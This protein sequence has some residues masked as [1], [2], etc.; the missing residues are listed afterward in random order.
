MSLRDDRAAGQEPSTERDSS[1]PQVLSDAPVRRPFASVVAATHCSTFLVVGTLLALVHATGLLGDTP[2]IVLSVAAP[3]AIGLGVRRHRPTPHWPWTLL[4]LAGLVWSV[5]GAVRTAVESTGDLSADRSLL[6]DA[7]AIGGYT[8]FAVALVRMVRAQGHL[9]RSRSLSLDGVIM[10]MSAMLAS[11]V[12]LVAP[13]L[14]HLDAAPIAKLS[15]V[16]YP[17]ISAGLV[18]VAARLAFGTAGRGRAHNLLLLGMLAILIGDVAYIPL[19]TH[20]FTDLP[21]RL[22]ELPYALAYA[23]IGAAALHPSMADTVRSM[24][25]TPARTNNRFALVAMALMTP[26]MMLLVWSPVST[27]ERVVVGLLAIGLATAAIVRVVFA[28]QAQAEVEEHLSHRAV[29]DELTGM[30]NRT[31]MIELVDRRLD[32]ARASSE[33]LALLFIDLDRFKLVNDTYGHAAGD[34]LLLAVSQRLKASLRGHDSVAR[35]SG[36]EFLIVSSLPDAGAAHRVAERICG[37]FEQP[38]DVIGAAWVTASVGVVVASAE[39]G[40]ADAAELIRDADTAMYEA[41]AAGRAHYAVFDP[42]MRAKSAQRLSI[43]NGLHRAIDEHEFEVFYQP[44]IDAGSETVHGVEALVRWMAPDGMVPPD[45][46]ISVAEDSGLISQIGEIVLRDACTQ[47]ARWRLLPGCENLTLSVNVSARQVIDVDLVAVV[48]E[49]LTETGMEPSALWLEITESLMISDNLDTLSTLS[50]LRNLG[51]H[52]AVDDFGTG[53][54]SLSY[55]HRYPVEQVKIDRQFVS[56]LSDDGDAGG[57][58][59]V[60]AAVIGIAEALDLSIVA[61]GVETE[62]Q[63]GHLTE[64]GCDL[65]Q[66]FHFSRPVPALDLG[67]LLI[68]RNEPE[69]P[70]TSDRPR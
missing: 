37:L 35:L 51:V 55:L 7:F 4:I 54:S 50:G 64:I 49:V 11:W 68:E 58:A 15:I 21:G 42:S 28:A 52:L 23:L 19:E 20:L 43:Y 45:Q 44:L 47:V 12:T 18:Y 6:P 24:R 69:R 57:D 22:L 27:V 41:K 1:R 9:T 34:Q 2:M 56:G 10:T 65:L 31:G 48:D 16:I 30:L 26:A 46:F 70:Q 63:V 66:G 40:D 14:F 61:E 36:D 59:A 33:T 3:V 25:Q 5:A 39:L 38:F 13:V 53:Y 62:W 8:L 29:T 17:P 67:P 32:A 60:V